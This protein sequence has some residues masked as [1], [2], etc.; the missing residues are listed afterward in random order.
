MDKSIKKVW[1]DDSFTHEINAQVLFLS[2]I[3][4]SNSLLRWAAQSS[5]NPVKN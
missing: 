3:V 1:L 5:A 2:L 4:G